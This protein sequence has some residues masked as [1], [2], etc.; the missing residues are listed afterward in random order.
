MPAASA[1]GTVCGYQ[2][3]RM[4]DSLQ[5]TAPVFVKFEFGSGTSSDAASLWITVGT[6]TDGVGGITGTIQ[7]K[8]RIYM[9]SAG[10]GS[11]TVASYF[12]GSGYSNR[13]VF[14]AR[15]L[16]TPGNAFVQRIMFSIERTHNANG[17]DTSQGV[18]I[19]GEAPSGYSTSNALGTVY[20]FRVATFSDPQTSSSTSIG[21]YVPSGTTWS[22]SANYVGICPV[23]FFLGA[24]TNPS[25]NLAVYLNGD[26][27]AL[28]PGVIS[29]YGTDLNW[30]PLGASMISN[31]ASSNA[32]S[33]FLIRWD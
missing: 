6:G 13:L 23:A 21:A 5:A 4:N 16:N 29:T 20:V 3:W 31:V 33:S 25:K 2:I 19:F 28:V 10:L 22:Y 30:I 15:S 27:P 8:T 7:D 17:G 18:M 24:P 14:V 11:I 26:L 12:Y 1:A 32:N 9:S